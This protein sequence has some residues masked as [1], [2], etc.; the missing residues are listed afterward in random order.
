MKLSF[1]RLGE[2]ISSA[3]MYGEESRRKFLSL[4][5][6]G[7]KK[8]LGLITEYISQLKNGK[9]SAKEAYDSIQEI[10]TFLGTD[11]PFDLCTRRQFTK[12]LGYNHVFQLVYS[13]TFEKITLP[14]KEFS[15]SLLD[16]QKKL[17]Y[18]RD[19]LLWIYFELSTRE[20]EQ[21]FSERKRLI[22][23]LLSEKQYDDLEETIV[24]FETTYGIEESLYAIVGSAEREDQVKGIFNAVVTTYSQKE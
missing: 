21:D 16:R 5:P 17:F 11:H 9:L 1:K 10:C 2:R 4:P 3:V 18:Y 15:A 20:E 13:W 19:E 14:L 12:Y 24:S 6:P 22:E 8:V 7:Q 23:K